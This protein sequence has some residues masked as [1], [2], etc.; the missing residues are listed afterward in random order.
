MKKIITIMFISFILI[1]SY[2]FL[3]KEKDNCKISE[4]EVIKLNNF[5][6]NP[7]Y[8][9]NKKYWCNIKFIDPKISLWEKKL[10]PELWK[11]VN[12]EDLILNDKN[13]SWEIPKEI[14]NL[15][16]LR[17]LWLANNNLS[18]KIPED[19][20]NLKNL[21]TLSLSNNNNLNW[22]IPKEILNN[23]ERL[24]INNTKIKIWEKFIKNIK[25]LSK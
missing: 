9:W 12:L 7:K 13:L 17:V 10:I 6:N 5:F 11:L 23:L 16:N 20:I 19:F 21:N 3:F 2:S 25:Y 18:W 8:V 1:G 4:L 14:W 15:K 24:E 22:K